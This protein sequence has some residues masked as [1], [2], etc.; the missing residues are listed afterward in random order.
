MPLLGRDHVRQEGL[1]SV[2]M[3]DEVDVE[4][5]LEVR[6]A[7]IENVES[8]PNAGIVEE[9]A[10]G[11][12][13]ALD[14][15]S[16]VSHGF[17]VGDIALVEVHVA[18]GFQVG[19]RRAQIHDS[20]TH[21]CA[22]KIAHDLRADAAGAAGDDADLIL[23]VERGRRFAKLPFVEGKASEEAVEAVDNAK[24]DEVLQHLDECFLC[25]CTG[26]LGDDV[27]NASTCLG[28]ASCEGEEERCGE[29]GVQYSIAK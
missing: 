27:E 14:S 16:D 21:A 23:G 9:D 19:G 24:G 11:A 4:D 29:P 1:D 22:R 12:E 28:R 20:D 26:D 15:A 6:V 8:L 18:V 17:W 2:P 13:V 10:D 5:L 25:G 3:R 7:N